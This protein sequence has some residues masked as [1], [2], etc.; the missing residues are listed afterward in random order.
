MGEIVVIGK[1]VEGKEGGRGDLGS[2]V[3]IF[4][5][6]NQIVCVDVAN[7]VVCDFVALLFGLWS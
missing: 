4:A 7:K 1:R 3:A 5:G 6:S 2:R